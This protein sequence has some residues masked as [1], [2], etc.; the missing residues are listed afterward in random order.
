[1]S[2][3]RVKT[4]PPYTVRFGTLDDLPGVLGG[5]VAVVTDRHVAA[6]LASD[7]PTSAPTLVL[8]PGER[9][10]SWE[11]YRRVVGFLAS[12]KL[13]RSGTVVALGGGVVGDLAG[14]AAATYLRGVR[15][16]QVPT[17]LLAMVDSSVGGKVGID[18]PEG[19]NLLG[20]FYQPAEVLVCLDA[21]RTLPRLH[22]RAGRAEMED[23]LRGGCGPA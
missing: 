3:V 16:V 6:A 14:F 9:T 19:K 22:Y 4:R 11:G 20:A 12:S 21:L 7:M 13:D 8:P 2:P 5:D 15:C 23:G 17:S 18:L 1:M 10:K